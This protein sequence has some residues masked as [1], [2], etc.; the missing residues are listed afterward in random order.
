MRREECGKRAFSVF[1][2]NL[3]YT[4][5]YPR[6]NCIRVLLEHYHNKT[7]RISE[8]NTVDSLSYKMLGRVLKP[9]ANT[10]DGGRGAAIDS[11]P[12]SRRLSS[13]H[14]SL[15]FP[16]EA[17]GTVLFWCLI[18]LPLLLSFCKGVVFVPTYDSEIFLSFSE[19]L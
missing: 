10:A 5:R 3:K 19:T 11:L 2:R 7:R 16:S 12:A 13:A 18:L 8:I 9:V 4:V 17:F 1:E 6:L 14:F 15:F